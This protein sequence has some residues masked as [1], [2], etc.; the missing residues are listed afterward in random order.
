[1]VCILR[2]DTRKKPSRFG[3]SEIRTL[4]SSMSLIKLNYSAADV[5]TIT[6]DNLA[7]G[8]C[9]E[10][11]YIDNSV[12]LYIDV[13]VGGQITVANSGLSA[14]G[15]IKVYAYASSDDGN[16]FTSDA[17]G[18]DGDI[19]LSNVSKQNLELIGTIYTDSSANAV[20]TFGPWSV[21]EQYNGFMPQFWG[22]IFENN[23]GNDLAN[24]GHQVNFEGVFLENI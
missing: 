12:S 6:L 14:N 9:R 11:N 3:I 1:M 17:T 4:Y 8:N 22:L 7:N 23:T 2:S 10:G 15:S 13:Y 19:T 18:I 20:Y 5:V 21:G 16:T 24:T